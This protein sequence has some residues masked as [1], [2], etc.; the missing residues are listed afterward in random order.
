MGLDRDMMT[1][2]EFVKVRTLA[3]APKAD[4]EHVLVYWIYCQ[5]VQVFR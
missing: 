3:C 1:S 5:R 4:F 2:C